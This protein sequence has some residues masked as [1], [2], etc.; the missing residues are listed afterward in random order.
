MTAQHGLS[1]VDLALKLQLIFNNSQFYAFTCIDVDM[2]SF[3][4]IFLF[5]RVYFYA[6]LSCKYKYNLVRW[7]VTYSFN[8]LFDIISWEPEVSGQRTRLYFCQ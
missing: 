1:S 5:L 4:Y 8:P 6:D 7:L 2:R 3:R